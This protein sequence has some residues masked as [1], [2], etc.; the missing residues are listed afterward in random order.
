MTTHG[1]I[2]LCPLLLVAG[3]LLSACG[4]DDDTADLRTGDD[5]DDDISDPDDDGDDDDDDDDDN[6]NNNDNDDVWYD[7]TSGLTWQKSDDCCY[8]WVEAGEYCEAL[9]GTGA[10][11]WR[12]PT[13]SELRTLIQG[14]SATETAGACGVTDECMTLDCWTAACN[15]C[16]YLEGP[17]L[18]GRYWPEGLTGIGY[19]YWSSTTVAG[20]N[21]AAWLANFSNAI[22]N[23]EYDILTDYYDVR[24]LWSPVKRPAQAR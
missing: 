16:D 12:L 3:V 7:P 22:V 1:L 11:G 14:C 13:I 21:D 20:G 10:G 18:E 19:W 8:T 17:G 24:C 2:C 5:D 23:K 4:D 6:D 9:N 15:G